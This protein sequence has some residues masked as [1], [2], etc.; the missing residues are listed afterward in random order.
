M[1]GRDK[2]DQPRPLEVFDYLQD[3]NF[4]F[5]NYARRSL[6][7]GDT[8]IASLLQPTIERNPF[9]IPARIFSRQ[10][11]PAHL[12]VLCDRELIWIQDEPRSWDNTHYGG[13]WHYIRLNKLANLTFAN[14]GSD[15]FRMRLEF[16]DSSKLD[17]VFHVDLLERAEELAEAICKLQPGIELELLPC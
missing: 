11:S 1:L 9:K 5:M 2:S 8:V 15:A 13:I 3:L 16:I 14:Q 6:M 7:P 12:A 4:K 17:F 10:I